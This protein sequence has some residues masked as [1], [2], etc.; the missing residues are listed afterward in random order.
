[1]EAWGGRSGGLF[2][3]KRRTILSG[4]ALAKEVARLNI[5]VNT[6][7]PGL[8]ETEAT[9]VVRFLACAK[10]GYLTGCPIKVDGGIP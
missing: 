9:A 7:C 1:M 3:R 5:T 2:S 8:L 4:W 10:A 6:A